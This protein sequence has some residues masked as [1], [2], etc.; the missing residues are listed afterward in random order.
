MVNMPTPH[1]SRIDYC[2]HYQLFAKESV[3]IKGIR[4][5]TNVLN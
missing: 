2:K 4:L 1:N 5:Q 3:Y